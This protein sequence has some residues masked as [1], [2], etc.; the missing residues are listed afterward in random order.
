MFLGLQ[1]L[2]LP[3]L[4]KCIEFD[5]GVTI[6]IQIISLLV[7]TWQ[8]VEAVIKRLSE[9][10]RVKVYLWCYT[11]PIEN[12][13]LAD[14]IVKRYFLFLHCWPEFITGVS[15]KM[16]ISTLSYIPG[17]CTNTYQKITLIRFEN[18]LTLI[19]IIVSLILRLLLQ[20]RLNNSGT[21]VDFK[22]FTGDLFGELYIIQGL[23]IPKILEVSNSLI[24]LLLFIF[25]PIEN[26]F[27]LYIIRPILTR[28]YAF[29]WVSFLHNSWLITPLQICIFIIVGL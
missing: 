17:V 25:M 7:E 20:N 14:I 4:N 5:C 1:I 8:N 21:F 29:D 23:I 6:A 13:C 22:H 10:S 26:T 24:P 11:S 9:I 12:I 28:I 18:R 19:V 16:P 2:W 15:T 3:I 27:D